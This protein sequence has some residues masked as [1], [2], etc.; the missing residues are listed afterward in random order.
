[1]YGVKKLKELFLD[2]VC[3]NIVVEEKKFEK[4]K[5]AVLDATNGETTFVLKKTS[6]ESLHV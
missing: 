4:F 5:K 6:W 3:L 1:M 2:K